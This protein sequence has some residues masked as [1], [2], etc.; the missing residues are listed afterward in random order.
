MRAFQQLLSLQPLFTI[1]SDDDGVCDDAV[2]DVT[3]TPDDDDDILLTV[4]MVLWGIHC[5]T[6]FSLRSPLAPC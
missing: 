5:L 2:L 6:G 1:A 4:L 3:N